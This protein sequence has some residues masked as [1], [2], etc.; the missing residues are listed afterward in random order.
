MSR[1]ECIIINFCYT[2]RYYNTYK[3][4]TFRKHVSSNSSNAFRECNAF[5]IIAMVKY[6]ISYRCHTTGNIY[7]YKVIAVIEYTITNTCYVIRNNY[8]CN[9]AIA[10]SII[11]DTGYLKSV[12]SIRNYNVCTFISAHTG[13]GTSC[14]VT[15]YRVRKARLPYCRN[16]VNIVP[17]FTLVCGFFF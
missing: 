17:I 11:A 15:I 1:D 9:I 10:K 5:K 7:A 4:V 3:I 12:K 2:F 8:T 6:C 14:T 16:S 13:D